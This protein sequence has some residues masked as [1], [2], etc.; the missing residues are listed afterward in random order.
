[1]VPGPLKEF[2]R[3]KRAINDLIR[4]KNVC[5]SVYNAGLGRETV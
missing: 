1:M 3:W 5:V 4:L 2:L